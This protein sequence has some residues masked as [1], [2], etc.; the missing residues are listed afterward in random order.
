MKQANING[1]VL[2]IEKLRDCVW[3]WAVTLDD[4]I[5]ARNGS[6]GRHGG[7]EEEA[8]ML[9]EVAYFKHVNEIKIQWHSV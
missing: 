4:K 2:T 8:M 3:W 6:Y 5:I 1:Y 9:A 7:S